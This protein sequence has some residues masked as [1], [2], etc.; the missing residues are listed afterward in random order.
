M[1]QIISLIFVAIILYGCTDTKNSDLKLEIE[2]LKQQ[3]AQQEEFIRL[4]QKK[5]TDVTEVRQ[6]FAELEKKQEILENLIP[7]IL[8]RLEDI[9][10]QRYKGKFISK[11]RNQSSKP[12]KEEFFQAYIDLINYM[13]LELI[14]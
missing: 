1:R 7:P 10:K 4:L 8:S 13:E 6:K 14:D 2:D 11:F 5:E 9:D 12:T 3:V